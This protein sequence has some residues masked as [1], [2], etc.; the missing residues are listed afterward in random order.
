M[1]DP[2]AIEPGIGVA[3][4]QSNSLNGK[5]TFDTGLP[6]TGITVRLYNIG[7]AGQD[8]KLAEVKSDG[9]GAYAFSYAPGPAGTVA[10]TTANLQVRAV[11]ASGNEVTVSG[12]LYGAGRSESLN[13]VVP[14]TIQPLAAEFQRLSSDVQTAITEKVNLGEAQENSQRQDLTL[15]NRSTNWDARL[16]ALAATAAQQYASTGLAQD[17]LYALYRVGLPTDPTLLATIPSA[18]IQAVLEKASDSGIIN[19]N[20]QQI[21]ATV[22]QFQQFATKT[23][24]ASTATG[25]PSSYSRLLERYF[26]NDPTKLTDF[27]NLYFNTSSTAADFWLQA[28]KL[29][30]P[31]ETLSALQLQGKFLYLTIN[32]APLAELLQ[33][34]ITSEDNLSQL[35][36]KDFHQSATWQKT[37]TGLAGSGGDAALSALIP[38]AY[39]GST[40]ADRLTAYAG[41]LA[42]KVR[43]SFPTETVARM[44]EN[45]E[46]KI[47]SGTTGTVPGF[48]RTASKLGYRMGQTPLN[49]FLK[50]SGSSLP[51]LD[52][53]SEQTLKNLHRIFQITPSTESFQTA[54]SLGFTSAYQIA[55]YTKSDFI[56]KY[57]GVFPAGEAQLVYGQAQT[58]SS[59]TF[60]FF[61]IAKQL[62]TS[63]PVYSL[64]SSSQDRQNAKNALVQQF[65]TMANLFGNIDF[66]QC[67]DCRSVLSPAAYFVDVL[68][69]L[70]APMAAP[71][72][73]LNLPLDV[74]I[75]KNGGITGRRPDLA[76]LPLTCEN[77]NTAMPYID[78]V[79]EILEYYIAHNGLDSKAAYD[80][81]TATT[82]ELTAEPQNIIPSVYTTTLKQAVYPLDLPFDLWIATVRG[83]LNYFNTDLAQVLD[84]LSPADKLE[85]FTSVPPTA[86]Y[87]SQ[88]QAEALQ[89]SPA[90]YA[91]FTNTNTANWFGLYGAYANEAVALSDLKN[92]ETL[93]NRLEVSYQG[94]VNLVETGFLNPGL[95]ALLFQFNRFGIDMTAAFQ[96]TNQP[97]YTTPPLSP[98]QITDFEALLNGITAQYKQQ[99]PQ[100][101]FN[102]ITWLKALLPAN[103]SKTVLVLADPDSG[104]DFG[105]TTLQYADGTPAAPLDFLKFNLLVRLANQLNCVIDPS[106]GASQTTASDDSTVSPW[107]LDE[108]DRALQT[109]FPASSLPAWTNAAFSAA[110]GNSWKTALAY[111]ADLDDLNTRLAPALGRIA[112]LPFW[113]DLATNGADPLY[114]QLFLTPSVLNSDFAFDDPNGHF[115]S[116]ASDLTATE[117]LMSGHATAVQGALGFSASDMAAI[118]A[119][120]GVVSPAAFNLDNLSIC[121][122]YSQLAQCLGL[123]VTDLIALKVMSGLNP[124]HPISGNP[125]GVLA[126]DVLWSQTLAFVKQVGVVENSGFDVEDLQYLLR[127]IFDPVGEYRSDPNALVAAVQAMGSG[128]AQLQTQNAVPSNFSSQPETLIDQRL[129]GLFPASMLT[130][131]FAQLNNAQTYT[132]SAT[133][134]SALLPGDFAQVSGMTLS[135]DT[136]STTQTLTYTGLLLD[137]QKAAIEQLNSQ[138]GL[139]ALLGNLLTGIQQQAQ[140]QLQNSINDVLGVWASLVQYEA[141]GLGV[142]SAQSISDPLGLLTR[143]D[144][145]LNFTYDESGQ[146]QWLGYR[147]VL[148]NAKLSALTAIN[149]SATLAALLTDVQQ[150]TLPAYNQLTASLLATWCN[151][152]TY[153][154]T[155]TGVTAANQ[156]N[157]AAFTA[158]LTQAQQNGTLVGAITAITFEYN[159]ASQTQVLTCSGVLTDTLR[160]QLAALLPSPVL[161]TLLQDARNAAV[162]EF[163]FL[164]TGLL[165]S[166]INNPDT[167]VQPVVGVDPAKQQ[168]FVKAELV[169]V[170][171]PL[172][173]QELTTQ[174]VIQTLASNLGA[175]PTLTQALLT[176]AALLNNPSDR[177]KSLLAAFLA[178][179]QPGVTASYFNAASVL[180]ASGTA[181]T[182]DTSDP[183]NTNP[184]ATVTSTFAGYLQVT[185]DGPYRFF[186]ELGNTGAQVTFTLAAPDPTALLNN[187]VIQA[188][189]TKNGDEASQFVQLK[190]GV[191]YQFTVRFSGLG[192]AGA[193]LL[194]Q[195]EN[196]PKGPL[197]QILLYP[198]Q[199]VDSF[200]R[201]NILLSKVVQILGVTGLD[202]RE[203]SYFA[204]NSANFNNLSLSALPT[205]ASD[206]SVPKAV[207]LFS[208]FLTLADYADLRKGPAGGTDGLIDVFQAASQT[209]PPTPPWNVLANLTRRDS[210]TV[211]DVAAALWPGQPA[212]PHFTNN[213]GIR[214]LWQALQLVAILGLPTSA[215]SNSTAIVNPTYGSPDVIAANFKNAVKAQY[216]PTQWLPI[217]QSVF[218]PLRRQK[219][220]ALVSYLVNKLGLENS[221]Q[222][223]EYFLVDPGMEPVVQTSRLR[224][225]MS[226]VQTFI[227]RCFLNLENGNTGK[228]ELNVAPNALQTDLWSWM[229]R[230]RVWQ[231]N[232]E[233]FLY[234]ENYMEPELRLDTTDLFQSL[235]SSLLQG[236]VT[237]DLAEKAFFDYLTGLDVRARLDIVATYLD[238]DPEAPQNSTLHVLGRTYGHP[239]KYFYRTYANGLWSG[240]AA[241]PLDIES[242]HIVLAVWRGHV[243]IFWLTF[244]T[245]TQ[246]PAGDSNDGTQLGVLPLGSLESAIQQL[247]SQKQVQIQLHWS[248][249]VQGKW[250]TRLSSDVN[251]STPINVV[252][253][254]DPRQVHPRVA[255]EIDSSGNEGALLLYVD[256][257]YPGANFWFYNL[258][259]GLAIASGDTAGANIYEYDAG[260]YKPWANPAF[261]IT[262]KNCSPDLNPAY[263]VPGATSPYNVS[264]I[265]ATFYTGSSNLS[266][267]FR[268]NIQSDGSST[269]ETETILNTVQNYEVLACSNL[270]A[271]PF[272]PASDPF[273]PNN[274][275]LYWEAGNLVSPFFFRDTSNPGAAAPQPT[276]LD[277]RTFF[278]QPSLTE[279]VVR[280]WLGWAIV[281]YWPAQV[282]KDPSLIKMIPI[283]PQVP[284]PLTAVTL[285]DPVYSLYQMRSQTDWLSNPA[286]TVTYGGT[287][288][289]KAGGIQQSLPTTVSTASKPQ[290]AL[291]GLLR[292][293]PLS[294]VTRVAPVPASSLNGSKNG[295]S[296][297]QK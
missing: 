15:L 137:W 84:T 229:K 216:T 31:T 183:T 228:P 59:V 159:A 201:A 101:T 128:I 12:T 26:A 44:A 295:S 116:P 35:T 293:E 258:L 57:G 187:P 225:A 249:Y 284:V 8:T 246:A 3:V 191:A 21:T 103:Y 260:I 243:N 30:I 286:V 29:G 212:V 91:V 154:A 247:K 297:G 224:L 177:G 88:I 236:D 226:S 108:I 72:G 43:L 129:S 45:G 70:N 259:T 86:Y 199:A 184:A 80:T 274:P 190:G 161:A 182:V 27:A 196:L 172:L 189:A 211:Q 152:Q 124:F 66:C 263:W 130:T 23:L 81:G 138:P 230:Y 119:D 4:M 64:S 203:L 140:Q 133:S 28:A 194:V 220:D 282:W 52:A 2:N 40:T 83:F 143:A 115:P 90:E 155:Q 257:P 38:P 97:G 16:I 283:V 109:F 145:S 200:S 165:A 157:S 148:T 76:A 120:A 61:S 42:R 179:G 235:E 242:D 151:V 132:A 272:L 186:A 296:G 215:I 22:G 268:T 170:F 158:A 36:D 48:L 69:F 240:W 163:Q 198:Q 111:L 238:Q 87:R 289:A 251:K 213:V 175:D 32:N 139:N 9:Q 114:A 234:P 74:L 82:A 71:N 171:A 14:S 195:G 192:S 107:T 150:Q 267:S 164:A 50:N 262:S 185:T 181:A 131:L 219:R 227:Q 285:G 125:L 118:L 11:G 269:V 252:D 63:P 47:D 92:A 39:T 113:T 261:R 167:Y 112:L 1:I 89:I 280:E 188:T 160:A 149:S 245:R 79:N 25:A 105:G 53:A 51:K 67:E 62:D 10:V 96:Y 95:Y 232:R 110:F 294:A 197:S 291:E 75:G 142:T 193:R 287:A 208:Q 73:A 244:I 94:L 33:G 144:P 20:E 117:Q 37:I 156:I 279:T 248:D 270:I 136:V 65:P 93:S 168:K 253:G 153:Q 207:A 146:I 68:D 266:A 292:S 281:P 46:L 135:Y 100:S 85:L 126:D 237:N 24:L 264:G 106:A 98:A 54:V 7:F 290:A 17:A 202:V 221:N 222:L 127:H 277:E 176:D 174:L 278:V 205:Q 13:L 276:F 56:A 265:D 214:R 134:A 147:G 255:K 273:G 121:Y 206:D 60:N 49:A 123:S 178:V 34:Q 99:N 239:H 231:A 19:Y 102:A 41:D 58:V 204:A 6:A 141:V 122:R 223:F 166:T 5:L 275:L 162:S 18:T 55:S 104:C 256:L 217:A 209:A 241:V 210:Q 78:I 254:F 233:I 218:D 77:T 169:Q 180:L 173:A 250:S 271:P 288:I